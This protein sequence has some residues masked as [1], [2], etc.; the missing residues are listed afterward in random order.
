MTDVLTFFFV[1]ES[2]IMFNLTFF[3]EKDA[4]RPLKCT[5]KLYWLKYSM[6]R[7]KIEHRR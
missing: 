4:A 1:S 3:N 2:C 6:K 5:N 7:Q